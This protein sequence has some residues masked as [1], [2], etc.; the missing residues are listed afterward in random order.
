MR[1]NRMALRLLLVLSVTGTSGAAP[2]AVPEV[3]VVALVASWA[4]TPWDGYVCS[5]VQVSES[6]V[7]TSAHC[8]V[9]TEVA[10][11]PGHSLCE[12]TSSIPVAS[13][14]VHPLFEPTT[15]L[16]DV[17]VLRLPLSPPGDT[18]L[19]RAGRKPLSYGEPTAGTA[20]VIAFGPAGPGQALG[21]FHQRSKVQIVDSVTCI[22][23]L[24]GVP[25]DVIW[26]KICVTPTGP[27]EAC[28]GWS[29]G[30]L[31]RDGRLLGL[32]S[33]GVGCSES[34]SPS[35]YEPI[36]A[37]EAADLV[38]APDLGPDGH[39]AN[40]VRNLLHETPVPVRVPAHHGQ[41]E[42]TTGDVPRD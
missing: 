33:S 32:V 25:S 4:A 26:T 30:A 31:V 15:L 20:E 18:P 28:P 38:D 11:A 39:G 1:R 14:K 27:S 5:G 21:C 40:A 42:R 37:R 19:W 13:S 36:S 7:L 29:G 35:L 10:V 41:P 8:V 6:S 24:P 2:V 34:G 9:D 22:R 12:P 23:E 16:H 17:A 3:P